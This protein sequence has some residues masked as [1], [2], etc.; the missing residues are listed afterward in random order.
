MKYY[1][2]FKQRDMEEQNEQDPAIKYFKKCKEENSLLLPIFEKIYR[3]TLCLQDY[4]LSDGQCQGIVEACNY[5]DY[6]KMNR[7]FFSNCGLTGNK[8]ATILDGLVLVKD[9]KSII[10]KLNEINELTVEKLQPLFVK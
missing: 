2:K 6:K 4:I 7:V 8:F 1:E 9:L 5:I 3:K 10:Y